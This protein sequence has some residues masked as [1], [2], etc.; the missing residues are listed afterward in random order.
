[1][2]KSIYLIACLVLLE[3]CLYLPKTSDTVDSACECRMHTSQWELSRKDLLEMQLCHDSGDGGRACLLMIGVVLPA[4][5]WLVSKSI[6]IA[7]NAVHWLE[8]QGVCDDG[9]LSRGVSSLKNKIMGQE[10]MPTI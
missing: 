1:M 10:V 3:A 8:Y 6:V 4:S 9:A 7:G 5:S 2:K